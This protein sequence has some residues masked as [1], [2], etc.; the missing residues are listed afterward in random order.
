MHEFLFDGFAYQEIE[1]N[2][3][4]PDWIMFVGQR[5]EPADPI[6]AFAH[7]GNICGRHFWCGSRNIWDELWDPIIWC[8]F[9]IQLGPYN[10][11]NLWGH[12]I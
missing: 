5:A 7:N 8:T 11:R 6:W 3:V 1:L 12:H 10:Y 2:I 4:K 9:C